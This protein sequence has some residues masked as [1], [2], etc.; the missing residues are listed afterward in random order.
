MKAPHRS[1][2]ELMATLQELEHLGVGFVSVTEA[3]DLTTPA[4]R[5]M[6]ALLAIPRRLAQEGARGKYS[7]NFLRTHEGALLSGPL[8]EG[9]KQSR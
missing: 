7:R 4:G 1:V 5:A 6:A 8:I 9:G 3:R 2:T